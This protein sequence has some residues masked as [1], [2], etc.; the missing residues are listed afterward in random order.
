MQ[1]RALNSAATNDYD[2][3]GVQGMRAS[4]YLISGTFSTST[5]RHANTV[6]VA[7]ITQ[8]VSVSTSSSAS[9]VLRATSVD[10][11]QVAS[12]QASGGSIA[13]AAQAAAQ[14]MLL[15]LFPIKVVQVAGGNV[16]VNRGQDA[17]VRVGAHLQLY[18]QGAPIIDRATGAMLSEGARSLAGEAVVTDVQ[19]NVST[20]R[21]IGSVA[22]SEG[23]VVEFGGTGGD[24]AA[25]ARPA[26]SGAPR[27]QRRAAP[28]PARPAQEGGLHF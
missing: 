14:K 27:A 6:S 8:T 15:K 10:G 16:Y 26:A 13:A 22:V 28:R 25:P 12:V 4:G 2:S 23:D 17:G 19:A 18:H 20:A 1:E 24:A 21:L 3:V 7:G 11:K 5:A 9:G